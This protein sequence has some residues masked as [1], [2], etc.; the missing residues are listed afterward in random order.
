MVIISYGEPHVPNLEHPMAKYNEVR[1]ET[2]RGRN[3]FMIK[4]DKL[5]EATI[6]PLYIC[7][8]KDALRPV[9]IKTSRTLA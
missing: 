9:S 5:K 7:N 8:E 2:Q 3:S 4:P 6:P 1:G